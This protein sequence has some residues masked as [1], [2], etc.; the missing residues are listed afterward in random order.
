MS[1]LQ[2]GTTSWRGALGQVGVWISGGALGSDPAGLA[3]RVEA[4]GYGALWVG[5]GNADDTAFDQIELALAGTS[6]L[7]LAT[8]IANIWA[9]EPAELADRVA[10]LERSYPGRFVLGLG[11]SHAPLVEGLGRRYERPLEAMV[12]FLDG[13]D[14]IIGEASRATNAPDPPVVLAAL[15]QRM[16]ELSRDRSAGAHPYLTTPKHTELAR[17]V[18]GDGPLLAPEQ[19]CVLDDDTDRARVTARAYLARY[20]RL[21]NYRGN[22]ERL[23][24]SDEDLAGSGSDRLVDDIVPHG[25][26]EHVASRV[27]AHLSA[28]ADH[29]CI[30]PLAHGGGT[31]EGAIEAL[32]TLLVT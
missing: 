26:V 28:G 13:L 24:Y 12:H 7:V 16:L 10:T 14:A 30:Q 1:G 9:W 20:L 25:T 2:G 19:A 4:L 6:S 29:V 23:S 11:V 27:R 32:A 18:L 31:D 21:P 8:G 15:G 5:G 17:R 22:L 3:I